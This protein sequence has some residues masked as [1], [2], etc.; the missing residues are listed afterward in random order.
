M[1]N[2][3]QLPGLIL[4][5]IFAF[6]IVAG[7]LLAVGTTHLYWLMGRQTDKRSRANEERAALQALA[8]QPVEID[9]D[10]M[11]CARCW[12]DRHPGQVWSLHIGSPLCAEHR[13]T[14][15]PEQDQ[16]VYALQY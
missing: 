3:Y 5:A 14:A 11:L 10:R 12:E 7:L 16:H 15:L 8:E 1:S 13:H 9:D 2:V 6:G 4:L